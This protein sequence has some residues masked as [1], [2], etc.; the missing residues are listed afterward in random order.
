MDL[1]KKRLLANASCAVLFPALIILASCGYTPHSPIPSNGDTA[2]G[3]PDDF[4]TYPARPIIVDANT[5]PGSG[6]ED[7]GVTIEFAGYTQQALYLTITNNSGFDIRYG[8]GFQI[9]GNQWGSAGAAD[10][11][12]YDLPS[13]EQQ[14]TYVSVYGLGPGEFRL[15]KNIII[16]QG[17]SEAPIT[18]ELQ[19]EF[20]IENTSIPQDICSVMMEVDQ[21]FA[22]PVGVLIEI[23]N[24]FESGYIYFDKYFWLQQ[25][26]GDAWSN[27]QLISSNSFPYETYSLA[28][29][30]VLSL[31][32]YWAW[33]YGE[34]PPG[35]YRI[36]KSFL[37]RT[38]D[39]EDTQYDL[40][41]TFTLDGEPIPDSILRDGSSWGHPFSGICTFRAEVT[42]LIDSDFHHVSMGSIGLL[43]NSLAP[44]WGSGGTGDSFYIWDNNTV[45][46]LD[47]TGE[48]VRFSD[49][50]QDAVLD[51]TFSGMI[52]TSDP[53][54]IG[55]ALFIQI[56]N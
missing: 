21:D 41:A 36:G 19:A 9:V 8:D 27:I 15:T 10:S 45:T 48:H 4:S 7:I 11:S 46:V 3:V 17:D 52:L 42:E 49:I 32:I 39:E 55:G 24:G 18:Y 29:R 40:V 20:S 31:S 47:S 37:H 14:K 33:L 12:F 53:A 22:T 34:L 51:I 50:P 1:L 44:F 28:P 6:S 13:G 54:H 25:N 56:I 2:P 35:E 38:E 30:Q 23:T 16:E 5:E 26:T 43:V